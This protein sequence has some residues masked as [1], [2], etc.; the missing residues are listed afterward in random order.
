MLQPSHSSSTIISMPRQHCRQHDSAS[1]SHHGHVASTT[2]SPALLGSIVA[3][4]TQ[5][6]HHTAAKSPRQRRRQRDSAAPHQHDSASKSPR[7]CIRQHDSVA[8]C[9]H[10]S[11]FESRRQL[12]CQHDSTYIT[13]QPTSPRQHHHQHHLGRAIISVTR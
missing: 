2:S 13:P 11:S 4:M 6:L 5:H 10:D 3:S 1:T 8:P 12:R 9:Q 7:Q